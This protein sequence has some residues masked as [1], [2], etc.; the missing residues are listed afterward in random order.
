MTVTVCVPGLLVANVALAC[1]RFAGLP[2][3]RVGVI[4]PVSPPDRVAVKPLRSTGVGKASEPLIVAMSTL[5]VIGPPRASSWTAIAGW[6]ASMPSVGVTV[7]PLSAS[8]M[9]M[10]RSVN[11]PGPENT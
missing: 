11:R 4:V 6:P 5:A 2:P 3:T 10:M 8:R 7:R 9:V 1:W